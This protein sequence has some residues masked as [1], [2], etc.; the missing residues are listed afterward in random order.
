MIQ[1]KYILS[2]A[3]LIAYVGASPWV[4]GVKEGKACGYS[5]ATG[6]NHNCADGLECI[7]P[8]AKQCSPVSLEKRG[9]KK[10]C[11]NPGQGG[12]GTEGEACETD[13]DC[14]PGSYCS[15][16]ADLMGTCTKKA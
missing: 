8:P 12:K 1:L 6:G 5:E 10:G 7:Y 14:V 3:A 9:R 11:K 2:F 4:E 16:W 15:E 13:A